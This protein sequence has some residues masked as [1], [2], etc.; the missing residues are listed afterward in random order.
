MIRLLDSNPFPFYCSTLNFVPSLFLKGRNKHI[1][2]S[3]PQ[4]FW[5]TCPHLLSR[6]PSWHARLSLGTLR[7][8]G[9]SCL[10]RRDDASG[11]L[12]DSAHGI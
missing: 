6:L 3:L 11:H 2:L 9:I 4:V 1:A 7:R 10:Q 5:T 8:R 12:E